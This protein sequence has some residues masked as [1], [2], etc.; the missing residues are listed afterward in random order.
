VFPQ[1]RDVKSRIADSPE[2][3]EPEDES[4]QVN[5]DDGAGWIA[6]AE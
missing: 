3:I 5:Q 6:L 1:F 2:L 4:A